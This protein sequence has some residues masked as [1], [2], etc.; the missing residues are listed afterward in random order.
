MV[1]KIDLP[2]L[3]G[4][5]DLLDITKEWSIKTVKVLIYLKEGE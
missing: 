1:Q 5:S 3:L 4:I 2:S